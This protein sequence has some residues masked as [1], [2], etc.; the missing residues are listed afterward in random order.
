MIPFG[1]RPH[2]RLMPTRPWSR[3]SGFHPQN[4]WWQAIMEQRNL[5][6]LCARM[7]RSGSMGA[8]VRRWILDGWKGPWIDAGVVPVP[9]FGETDVQWR[10]PARYPP[11]PTI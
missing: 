6:W 9:G 8:R 1:A 7:V 11:R 3:N 2:A 5:A 4:T 10:A